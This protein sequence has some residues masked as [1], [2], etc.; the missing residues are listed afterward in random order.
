[1]KANLETAEKKILVVDD[2]KL[3]CWAMEKEI[4]FLNLSTH[5][6]ETGAEAL[7]EL[8]SHSYDLVFLDIHLPDSDGIELLREIGRISPNTKVIIMS[9]DASEG[10][11]Q[12]AFAGGA[13]QFLEKPFDL[14]DIHEI[15]MSTTDGSLPKRKHTRHLCC[16]PA[17]FSVT[18]PAQEESG[19]DLRHLGGIVTDIHFEGL[20]LLTEYPL[21]V[22]QRLRVR[23]SVGSDPFL[24]LVPPHTAAEVVWVVPT[25]GGVTAGLK[26]LA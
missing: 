10:N 3:I 1:M 12:R 15:L 22:G 2:D 8:G 26:F 4:S 25:R 19:R 11:R 17:Q 13:L 7:S 16:L 14:S 21:R 9:C 5:S 18:E 6:V 20:R 23:I 24:Q